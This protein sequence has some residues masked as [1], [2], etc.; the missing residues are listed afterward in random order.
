[1]C[2]A[3]FYARENSTVPKVTVLNNENS[4]PV[5]K[6]NGRDE[7]KDERKR[8]PDETKEIDKDKDQRIE[9]ANGT[10]RTEKMNGKDEQKGAGGA[11][12]I[13]F[14]LSHSTGGATNIRLLSSLV[15]AFGCTAFVRSHR[16]GG[17]TDSREQSSPIG[18]VGCTAVVINHRTGE[19]E[20]R[21][22][23]RGGVSERV[24]RAWE[25]SSSSHTDGGEREFFFFRSSSSVFLQFF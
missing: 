9:K 25:K 3:H 12:K 5:E 1:M 7:Q 24:R 8:R 16:R 17:A 4:W 20:E 11:D 10:E 21:K 23:R 13:E 2:F 18:T 15:R 19:V 6:G 14:W 22:R